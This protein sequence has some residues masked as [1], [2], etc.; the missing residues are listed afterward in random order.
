MTPY[1]RS[2]IQLST[3]QARLRA[4][5]PTLSPDSPRHMAGILLLA[6]Q[7]APPKVDLLAARL[8]L[9]R[10]FVAKCLRRC[11]DN[12][13]VQNGS[14]IS[15]WSGEAWSED[16]FWADVNVALG[17]WWRRQDGS[18][19]L[20]WIEAG[21]WQKP[22]EYV[23]RGG[24]VRNGTGY[25]SDGEAQPQ[26]NLDPLTVNSDSLWMGSLSGE[27]ETFV[28]AAEA[29]AGFPEPEWVGGFDGE[30]AHESEE[31]VEAAIVSTGDAQSVVWLF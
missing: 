2:M 25:L 6:L 26:M 23:D 3:A 29:E 7:E 28:P 17:K 24:E 11:I 21:G 14:L 18:G 31:P 13:V 22:Y 19:R 10:E 30:D 15:G 16:A 8:R 9:P 27:A 5:D 20:E 4:M 1:R 12:G